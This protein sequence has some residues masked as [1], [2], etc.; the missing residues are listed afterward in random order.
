MLNDAPTLQL[1]DII[2]AVSPS[3][4]PQPG[5]VSEPSRNSTPEPLQAEEIETMRRRVLEL[6]EVTGVVKERQ[7]TREDE[8]A[9]MVM[10]LTS[11]PQP[12]SA[13]LVAQADTITR[14][15]RQQQYLLDRAQEEREMHEAERYGW[16]RTSEAL[17]G[18]VNRTGPN[19]YRE[20]DYGKLLSSTESDNY[21]LRQKVCPNR[22]L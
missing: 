13:Q 12:S 21:S 9:D 5:H 19:V 15:I 17:I 8:L 4:D 16:A 6:R 20:H 2:V 22:I 18:L 3:P 14:L 10:R 7:N 1:S 11:T